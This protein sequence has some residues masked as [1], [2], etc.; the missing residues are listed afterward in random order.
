MNALTKHTCVSPFFHQN[1]M[2]FPFQSLS[3]YINH[4]KKD[5]KV[6]IITD[7]T[8]LLHMLAP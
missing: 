7:L 5:E 6:I 1:T 2:I 8:R 4:S 3:V